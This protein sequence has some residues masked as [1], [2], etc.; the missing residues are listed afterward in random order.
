M[1]TSKSKKSNK[2]VAILLVP[3]F[4]SLLGRF[5]MENPGKWRRILI[6]LSPIYHENYWTKSLQCVR[7]EST[8]WKSFMSKTALAVYVTQYQD[9]LPSSRLETTADEHLHGMVG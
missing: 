9:E 1:Q 8:C 7:P 2:F 6:R 3:F 5:R 4:C